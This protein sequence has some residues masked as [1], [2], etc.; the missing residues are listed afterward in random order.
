MTFEVLRTIVAIDPGE[1]RTGMA[2]RDLDG[3]IFCQSFEPWGVCGWLESQPANSI[4]H[5]VIEQWVAY[6]GAAAGNAWRKLLEVR[7]IGAI[8]RWCQIHFVPHSFQPTSILVPTQALADNAGYRW[9][10]SNRDEKAAETHLYRHLH[11][12]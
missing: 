1:K 5:V 7:Q 2:V 4:N 6:P 8:E 3:S 11:L 10:A 12:L 9:R